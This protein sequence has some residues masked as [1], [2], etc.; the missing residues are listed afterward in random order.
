MCKIKKS[1]KVD[2]FYSVFSAEPTPATM[3]V[4]KLK[5]DLT[6]Q[7]KF[8][9]DLPHISQQFVYYNVNFFTGISTNESSMSYV[10]TI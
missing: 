5:I 6:N 10:S 4:H 9:A 8:L 1:S 2:F 3:N 7:T